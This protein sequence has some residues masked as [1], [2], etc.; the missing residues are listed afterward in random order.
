MG[1]AAGE[2]ATEQR[3]AHLPAIPPQLLLTAYRNGLFPMAH[4][5]GELYWHDPDPRAVFPLKAIQPDE[6]TARH[7]RSARLGITF[8]RAFE[9]VVRACAER[10][11]TWIDE[12]IIRSYHALHALGQGHSLEVWEGEE[13]VGGIYGVAIGG[14]FFGESMF[15]RRNNMGKVAF[16]AL[17]RHL[18]QRGYVLFDSQYINPFTAQLGAVEI[19]RRQY[20]E[21]LDHAL[22]LP[23]TFH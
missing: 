15:N 4:E 2:Q 8:D 20:R 17:V 22:S 9:Q 5:D 19:P 6:R 18:Q 12:R 11:E 14:A 3:Y 21:E 7:L 1:N 13:L 16:H 10:E 23:V